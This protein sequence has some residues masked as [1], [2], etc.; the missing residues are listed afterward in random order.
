MVRAY[1]RER[2][3]VPNSLEQLNSF[4]NQAVLYEDQRDYSITFSA[5]AAS[6]VSVSIVED[7]QFLVPT[8][9]DITSVVSQPGNIVYDINL[10]SIGNVKFEWPALPPGVSSSTPSAN[11]YRIQG[12]FD[13][14][15]WAQSTPALVVF[16]DRTANATFTSSI[17][18][19]STANTANTNVW[20][21]STQ[22]TVT[23]SSN[24]IT[25]PTG[26]TYDEDT[27][28]V[29][30][31]YPQI[32]DAYVGPELYTIT[33]TPNTANAV[34][35]LSTTG[36]ATTSFNN[37][38]KVMTITG[39]KDSVNTNLGN[40]LFTP[41]PD[42]DQDFFFTY[43]LTNPI[44]NLVTQVTQAANIANTNPDY[45]M[46]ANYSENTR[47]VPIQI[48]DIDPFATSYTFSVQQVSGNIG[49]WIV[50]NTAVGNANVTY[51]A[52]S[53]VGNINSSNI[54]YLPAVA[55]TGNVTLQVNFSKINITGNVVIATNANTVLSVATTYPGVEN[56][57]NKTY[58]GKFFNV[59]LLESAY[60]ND[61]PDYGQT[62]RITLTSDRG[63]WGSSV[64]NAE[65][66][67]TFVYSG[68]TS[69]INAMFD[70]LV[71]VPNV[72]AN[73][74]GNWNYKQERQNPAGNF[75]TQI[76]STYVM[77][78][79]G[80]AVGNVYTITI[81]DAASWTP[82]QRERKYTTANVLVVGG[83]GGAGDNSAGGGGG[84][85]QVQTLSIS[86]GNVANA[87]VSIGSGGPAGNVITGN[88][89]GQL[90]GNTT[91]TMNATTT[92]A[93]GG[94]PGGPGFNI[95]SNQYGGPGGGPPTGGDGAIGADANN[96]VS[97][98]YMAAGGGGWGAQA[99]NGLIGMTGSAGTV[100]QYATGGNGTNGW[101]SN[102][103]GANVYYAGGGGGGATGNGGTI[104][105]G[106]AGLGADHFG[107][108]GH[109]PSGG[110]D[111]NN[112]VVIIRTI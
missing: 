84:G 90:G 31:G 104:T 98:K 17:S 96:S 23:S 38:T 35:T 24:E 102:I 52:N 75:V 9:I 32:I 95:G 25:T 21:W 55:D 89:I 69:Q 29:V 7:Q 108:G 109:N 94:R 88:G 91:F 74:T 42:Y 8:G 15:T 56:V 82:D 86:V 87:T 16:K 3:T 78:H 33:M 46:P 20:S 50:N 71:F 106:T 73:T 51:T 68:N 111:G 44:S 39:V 67:A 19:P 107:G 53:T 4:S 18:Y 13:S 45:T 40:I 79:G 93:L 62:Y 70:N 11:V 81:N 14:V 61:G 5:N 72:G 1:Q 97:N 92:T 100:P 76:D 99:P 110:G 103:T 37:V 12:Y 6:N 27:A 41:Y 26:F 105:D 22:V 80:D 60:I 47:T 10:S 112:G 77:T 28:K 64:A 54:Q 83:G 34:L 30:T 2:S 85:G 49:T 101:V 48:E 59:N 66:Q 36:P 43:S 57:G 58:T 65:A 63:R